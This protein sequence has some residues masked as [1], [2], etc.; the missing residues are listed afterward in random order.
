[1]AKT[2]SIGASYVTDVNAPVTLER[3]DN[4]FLYANSSGNLVYTQGFAA[5][6]FG[7]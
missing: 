1:M 7:L 5:S 2:F 6:G 4:G 3:A